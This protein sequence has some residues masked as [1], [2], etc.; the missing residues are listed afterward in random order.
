[1]DKICVFGSEMYKD[2]DREIIA[3]KQGR[4]IYLTKKS[5]SDREFRYD[6][7][8]GTFERI[9]HYKKG[10][11][12]TPVKTKNITRW[13]TN[14]SIFCTDKKFAKVVIANKYYYKNCM[15]SSGVRFIE[16]LN[17]TFAKRYEAWLSLGIEITDIEESVKR[18]I[19]EDKE[20]YYGT[21][22]F[23]SSIDYSPSSIDKRLL[24]YIQQ[25]MSKI[26]SE[27]LRDFYMNPDIDLLLKMSKISQENQYS[28]IFHYKKRIYQGYGQPYRYVDN[29][30]FDLEVKLG[31]EGDRIRR[32]LLE[33][34]SDYNL[35]INSFCSFL[36]RAYNVEGLTLE[37]LFSSSH[38]N[39]YLKME[40][41]LKHNQMRKM[42]KYP[43]HFLTQFHILKK[44]YEAFKKE[45][46]EVLFKEQCDKFRYLEKKYKKYQIVVPERIKEIENEADELHHCVRTYIDRVVDGRTLI[47][48]LRD[49]EEPDKP[50]VTI[51]VKNGEVTQAYGR[52]DG[53]PEEDAIET[54]RKWAHEMKLGL[55]WA[56]AGHGYRNPH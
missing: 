12:I 47:C 23:Y 56:W 27:Q 29:N 5:D 24:K 40:K 52:Y 16:A 44:E 17:S 2:T 26:S 20:Y 43:S 35:D 42:N 18:C 25:N 37:D 14:C 30:I 31:W 21:P 6:I 55:S 32:R 28:E 15:Y 11:K 10:D 49:N 13:F 9:N 22:R 1:M 51:E 45:Y 33:A 54:M 7:S 19:K 3:D 4:Y 41:A 50:L 8:T 36:L 48:F 53:K 34:I 39:D 38:Y 46:D